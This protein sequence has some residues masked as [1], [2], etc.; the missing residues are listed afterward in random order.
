VA[1]RR[2]QR[3]ADPLYGESMLDELITQHGFDAYLD[4]LRSRSR[5][6][7]MKFEYEYSPAERS[8]ASL[9]V[10]LENSHGVAQLSIWENGLA[11]VTLVP[12]AEGAEPIPLHF[13]P[14]TEETFHN[15][16]ARCFRFLRDEMESLPE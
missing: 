14:A 11:D 1:D 7:S 9:H 4:G 16:L 3:N 12:V 8:P 6:N 10:T 15:L 13:D 2:Q 5:A